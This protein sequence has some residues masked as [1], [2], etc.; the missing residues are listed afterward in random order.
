MVWHEIFLICLNLIFVNYKHCYN[1]AKCWLLYSMHPL[2]G[3][4]CYNSP[5]R[6]SWSFKHLCHKWV[7]GLS[8]WIPFAAGFMERT[9][10]LTQRPEHAILYHFCSHLLSFQIVLAEKTTKR[11]FVKIKKSQTE[12]SRDDESWIRKSTSQGTVMLV[13]LLASFVVF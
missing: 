2:E 3:L 5:S 8:F 13:V 6:L 12:S 7:A 9:T 10:G 4:L 11:R 1:H